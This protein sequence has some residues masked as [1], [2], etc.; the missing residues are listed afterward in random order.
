[1]RERD[2]S[3]S[4]LFFHPLPSQYVLQE[5]VGRKEDGDWVWEWISDENRLLREGRVQRKERDGRVK[6]DREID[7]DPS[8]LKQPH[9][10]LSL[11]AAQHQ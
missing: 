11:A 10:P 2:G 7:R 4:Y 1:M 3:A 6:G 9:V 8:D 5:K